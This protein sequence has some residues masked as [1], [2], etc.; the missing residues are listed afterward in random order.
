MSTLFNS[1]TG[2]D[3]GALLVDRSEP[4]HPASRSAERAATTSHARISQRVRGIVALRSN[5][6][7]RVGG[8][9]RLPRLRRI[10]QTDDADERV[11]VDLRLRRLRGAVTA[12]RR[13]LLR[14]LLVLGSALPAQAGGRP[15]RLAR[16]TARSAG[17]SERA[18][19]H[20]ATVFAETV[21]DAPLTAPR[22]RKRD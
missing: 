9:D 12:A 13:R 7:A 1:V 15:T 4:E 3:R 22:R 2:P 6:A 10:E 16:H 17:N 14:V 21:I 19:L 11:S 5:R 18:K 20:R 8:D